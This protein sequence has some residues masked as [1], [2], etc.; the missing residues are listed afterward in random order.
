MVEEKCSIWN[1][2]QYKQGDLNQTEKHELAS[3][4]SC[5][6]ESLLAQNAYDQQAYF[7]FQ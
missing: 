7:R 1:R 3:K 4:L 6:L 2:K 5:Q